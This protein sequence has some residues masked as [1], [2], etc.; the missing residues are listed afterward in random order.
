MSGSYDGSGGGGGF[1]RKKNRK[2]VMRS[3]LTDTDARLPDPEEQEPDSLSKVS[4]W[5]MRERMKTVSVALVCCMNIGVDPPDVIKTSPCARLECWIDPSSEPPQ[6]ALD[7]IGKQLQKQ[8]DRWQPRARYKLCLDPTV[9]E[10][11]KLCVFLR[12]NAKKERVLFH[13][14]GHGVPKPT[15]NG[16]LW[17][18]NKNYTQYIPLSI[19]EL[20]TWMGS[21]SIYVLDCSGAG[22]VVNWYNHFI[23][24]RNKEY[25][26]L[27]MAALARG[28]SEEVAASRAAAS[29][30]PITESILLAAC[31][32]GELLPTNA[33]LPADTFTACL[34]TPVKMALRWFVS[35]SPHK[36]LS[37]DLIDSIPGRLN[38]RRTPLGELNWIFTAITDTIA[39]NTLPPQVFQKLFRQD[40]LVASLFRNFLLA[41]R[42]LRAANCTP[43]SQ[44]PLPET[45]QH[46]MWSAWDLAADVCLSQMADHLEEDPQLLN[47][48]PSPFFAD[49]LTAFEVWLEFG[50]AQKKPPEQLPIVLQ[51]L[52][53]QTHRLRALRL[54]G[55]FLDQGP[56]AVNLALSVGIFPYVLKLLQSPAP[57]LRPILVFIWAKIL[58]LDKSCQ[59][60]LVK[61]N[62]HK[63]FITVLNSNRMPTE[64]RTMAAFVLT[65]ILD[66]CRPGQKA[67]LSCNLLTVCLN[68]LADPDPQLRRWVIFCLSK[69]W[70]NNQDA[71]WCAVREGAHERLCGL[72]S[73]H[74][75]EVRAAAVYALGTFLGGAEDSEQRT[76]IEINLGLTLPVVTAD[77]SPLVRRELIAA[78]ANLVRAYSN[79]FRVVAAELF[80]EEE[81]RR[82]GGGGGGSRDQT[83]SSSSGQALSASQQQTGAQSRSSSE[84]PAKLMITRQESS[85]YGC[86]W[87]V[88]MGLRLDPY[89]PLARLASLLVRAV[90]QEVAPTVQL[91]GPLGPQQRSSS[92]P[93]LQELGSSA[94]SGSGHHHSSSAS[95]S[96]RSGLKS[97]L[98]SLVRKT[99]Q[100]PAPGGQT[101]ASVPDLPSLDV[102]SKRFT[103]SQRGQSAGQI[104]DEMRASA[105]AAAALEP[106]GAG[107][108]AGGQASGDPSAESGPLDLPIEVD[109]H[110]YE[111]SCRYFARPLLATR[112]EPEDS[113]APEALQRAWR[114]RR[115]QKVVDE[116]RS[117]VEKRGTR[118]GYKV[119]DQIGALD[120]GQSEVSHV[121]YHPFENHLIAADDRSTVSVWNWENGARATS[122]SNRNRPGS[123]ISSLQ[124]INEHDIALLATAADDGTV[125]VWRD[126]SSQEGPPS[127]ATAFRALTDL[128][129]DRSSGL[130]LDWQQE[131]GYLLA[132]GATE[133]IRIWDLQRELYVQDIPTGSDTC[134]TSLTSAPSMSSR[135]V[136][137]GCGDGIVRAYDYRQSRYRPAMVFSQHRSWIV[138]V[139]IP[140]SQNMIF[141]GD[142]DGAIMTW[143]PR[144]ATKP[145]LNF[146]A[147]RAAMTSMVV[148]PFAQ[149]IACGS[150]QQKIKVFNFQGDELNMIRYHV[151]FLGQRIGPVSCLAFHPHQVQLAAGATDSIISIYRGN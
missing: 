77:G 47:W 78:L 142:I 5:R 97:S 25:E 123:R 31:S 66:H 86:L 139:Q 29:A 92:T 24:Q 103:P 144:I 23:E 69:L 145:V 51:V 147:F 80:T 70:E 79:E 120:N 4:K 110:Y 149:L 59:M 83:N 102:A 105:V 17:V 71:K 106:D 125:R 91:S 101:N 15:N 16:E 38:D 130:I 134:I 89:R 73:D 22:L 67:C 27:H 60:D 50:A 116:A 150:H 143:D 64:E 85:V 56:W 112:D 128:H 9:D 54:L 72:L 39:W 26:R 140:K 30:A 61:D 117:I 95:S 81:R 146:Q 14:N 108:G 32:A 53:S 90:Q 55:R 46:P 148:H 107:G 8:Y 109:S 1:S 137:G 58:A 18:F 48:E 65:V 115:N 118:T 127:L 100:S 133:S 40:L 6:K 37:L 93:D 43:V 151:G 68:Q 10:V 87:K 132:S 62:G 84:D 52:L 36:G 63:Y 126:Y 3:Y 113:T 20:Q 129:R 121:L 57:N 12:R 88:V 124:L 138:N 96:S 99:H 44:P 45:H 21:P 82:G 19:Y 7:S 42:I 76:N 13:Y 28:E 94:L 136:I 141:S 35:T 75:P 135:L 98:A 114:Q 74:V 34:T 131:H 11:K 33:Q 49:Q 122:F 41:E 2:R 119:Q 104:N 111:D